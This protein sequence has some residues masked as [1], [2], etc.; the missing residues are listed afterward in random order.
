MELEFKVK[1]TKEEME[2]CFRFDEV[3][4]I[5]FYEKI[6]P[7]LYLVKIRLP[8]CPGLRTTGVSTLDKIRKRVIK[9][10]PDSFRVVGEAH[11]V[12]RIYAPNEFWLREYADIYGRE[13]GIR[14]LSVKKI[15]R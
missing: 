9:K 3:L 10:C 11:Y 13:F 2:A 12:R 6:A 14:L 1:A 7:E 15:E 4:N 8:E 5:R